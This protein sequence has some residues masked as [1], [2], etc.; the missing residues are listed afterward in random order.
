MQDCKFNFVGNFI[1]TSFELLLS[2]LCLT[3]NFLFGFE[4]FS[5]RYEIIR[6]V[7][8]KRMHQFSGLM[9]RAQEYLWISVKSCE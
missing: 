1:I 7:F 3:D 4:L 6:G 8:D 9:H 2:C 5:S